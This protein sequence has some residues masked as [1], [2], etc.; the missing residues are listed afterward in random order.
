VNDHLNKILRTVICAITV[1]LPLCLLA[2]LSSSFYYD[3]SNHLWFIGYFGEF[4]RQHHTMP[5]YLHTMPVAGMPTPVFY[6]YLIYPIL[7]FLSS[8]LGASIALRAVLVVLLLSEYLALRAA[9]T[10]VFKDSFPSLVLPTVVLWS[11]YALTNLYNR[12]ALL[13]YVATSLLVTS[14]AFAIASALE[15][16]PAIRLKF[17]WLTIFTAMLMAGSHPP[18]MLLGCPL[19]LLLGCSLLFVRWKQ[20]GNQRR[21]LLILLVLGCIAALL[22]LA[23]W[24]QANVLLS[25][26]LGISSK[27]RQ[28][29][30]FP[31]RCDSLLGRFSPLPYDALSMKLGT[32]VSTPFLEAPFDAPLI[33]FLLGSLLL[34][35]RLP[36]TDRFPKQLFGTVILMLGLVWFAL[37]GSISLWKPLGACVPFLAGPVQ[38]AYRL[39]SHANLG[40]LIA[41]LGTGLLLRDRTNRVQIKRFQTILSL[42]ALCTATLSLGIKL[43]HASMVELHETKSEYSLDGKRE[44]L[45]RDGLPAAASDY[46]TPLVFGTLD[47]NIAKTM[48]TYRFPV[49]LSGKD[50]GKIGELHFRTDKSGW[51]FLNS[52][53]F[54]WAKVEINGVYPLAMASV[55][56]DYRLGLRLAAGEHQ[57]SWTWSPPRSW[58]ILR[59]LSQWLL[60]T[61]FLATLAW[62][63][64]PRSTDNRHEKT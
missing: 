9:F 1:F 31:D 39:V 41:I 58:R 15:E 10:R 37:L 2:D 42:L 48:E 21:P 27:Y 38:F 20:L 63:I 35:F 46:A 22:I 44:G 16:A 51:V 6:G 49:G 56:K 4:F 28:L 7:G 53:I 45:V 30:Y 8:F 12:S 36:E 54:P 52:T 13:E 47:P 34:I 60:V 5:E 55:R 14:C 59:Q 57:A 25:H 40:L 64:I 61:T 29:D 18:T 32:A 11:T 19:L 26:D 50:F 23:P 33:I 43:R 17:A 62:C 24:I 3:W